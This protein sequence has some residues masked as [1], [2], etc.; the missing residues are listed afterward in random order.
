MFAPCEAVVTSYKDVPG[1]TVDEIHEIEKLKEQV[2]FFNY[3]TML[4]T[5]SFK[6]SGDNAKGF[7]ALFCE[8]LSNLFGIPFVPGFYEW[9]SLIAGLES[10]EIAFTGELTATEER[11]KIYSMTDPIALR[12]I[13]TFRLE[14]SPSLENIAKERP[15]RYVFLEGTTTVEQVKANLKDFE[16]F[17]VN[18]HEN[19]YNM[20]KQ[21]NA[22]A[23]F[24]EGAAEAVFDTYGDVVAED[25]LPLIYAEVSL[26]TQ[27]E[28][29]K[30]IIS[31]VQ[32]MLKNGGVEHLS[33]LYNLGQQEYV[34]YKLSMRFSDEERKYIREN[35]VI[36]FVAQRDEYPISFY[37]SYEKQWQGIA[38]EVLED[39]EALTGLSFKQVKTIDSG[40]THLI[41]GLVPEEDEEERFIYLKTPI[42]KGYYV[43]LSKADYRNISLNDVLHLR[44]GLT[45]GKV[46]ASQFRKWFPNHSNVVIYED[47]N[48]A[49]TGL[50]NDEIDLIMTTQRQFLRIT[51]YFELTGYKVNFAFHH[52]LDITFGISNKDQTLRSIMDKTLAMIDIEEIS[53]RWM[54][55]TYDYQLKLTRMK[56]PWIIG[57]S[58]LIAC[59]FL[60][61]FV[62]IQ[63]RKKKSQLEHL[64]KKRTEELELKS[65]MLI[66]VMDS[67]PSFV[68][69]KD[70]NLKYTQCNASI[71]RYFNVREEDIIGKDEE[72]LGFL[73][74]ELKLFNLY[75]HKVI[76]EGIEVENEISVSHLDGTKYLFEVTLVPHKFKG[77]VIGL[78]GVAH[79]ITKRKAI[80][81]A[82]LA[83]SRSKSVFLANM[84]HEIRTPMNSIVGFS[85]L[86]LSDNVSLKTK[87]YLN[88]ILENSEWLLQIIND[89]LDISKIEAGQMTLEKIPFDLH[90]IFARCQTVIAPKTLEK[91]ILLYCY[92]EPSV[93]RKLLGDPMRLRQVLI[94]LLSNAVKFTNVGTVKLYSSIKHSTNSNTTIYFE[95]K[96]SGIGI[97]KEQIEKIFEPFVQADDSVTRRYGG[98]GLGLTITRNIIEL[99]GGHLNVESI[100]KV[101]SKFSFELTFDTINAVA[102]IPTKDIVIDTSEKPNFN[103]EVLICEDNRMN[104]MVISEHL[105][106]VGLK[107]VIAGNGKIGLDMVFDRMRKGAKFFDLIF[108]DIQ[109]PVMDGLEAASRIIQL[110]TGIPIVAMTANVMSNDRE[111]YKS[112]GMPDCIG[113]PFTTQELWQC[114]AKYL[115]SSNSKINEPHGIYNDDDKLQKRLQLT[116]VKDNQEKFQEIRYAID[117]NDI[118][119]ANRLAHTLKSNA[120]MIGE[121]FLQKAAADVESLLKDGNNLVTDSALSTL[122]RELNLVLKELE[123]LLDKAQVQVQNKVLNTNEVLNLLNRL[124]SMLTNMNPES[125]NLLDEI[126]SIPETD[127]LAKHIENFDFKP[128]LKILSEIKKK[129]SRHDRSKK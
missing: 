104:Q 88:K 32:K 99:M 120:G 16:I 14:G 82:A 50:E 121:P 49:V 15:L 68:F 63:S 81:E 128:A 77:S 33:K 94:N 66:T 9:D 114:L 34:K 8:W 35:S 119:L 45:K 11:R 118:K 76:D 6:D 124:K 65:N 115:A 113:K 109:M 20:L 98:T 54:R 105:E 26:A 86:A 106:R 67:I 127:E 79:N 108:M 48:N 30:P 102:D 13:K 19:A 59:L 10:H 78:V 85:E 112:H 117:K 17:L 25:F 2:K 116:F 3:G 80:E 28:A 43:L 5:E 23:F 71:E 39:I 21:K 74:E 52:P 46:S 22:D 91:G 7:S 24:E 38:L 42:L 18:S 87:D 75:S 95:V 40:K 12:S 29:L 110:K 60:I 107:P 41:S 51:N 122:E 73:P 57:I 58:A 62:F 70:L 53:D 101:G 100:P 36:P 4:G 103:G 125:I 129:W 90:D 84:S 93:G 83:A 97:A 55:K 72:S 111:I 44:I 123:P 61:T 1:I 31:V 37:N 89:I 126:R 56:I 64:V 96:D 27:I 92:A 69:C 47:L